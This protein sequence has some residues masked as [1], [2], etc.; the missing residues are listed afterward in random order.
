MA[1][2]TDLLH[3]KRLTWDAIESRKP[4]TAAQLARD[5]DVPVEAVCEWLD[6]ESKPPDAQVLAMIR[7]TR[8]TEAPGTATRRAPAP[9]NSST[10]EKSP[11]A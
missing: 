10:D 2:G 11:S 9:P 6:G 1:R 8:A 7:M 4:A 5:L 3:L